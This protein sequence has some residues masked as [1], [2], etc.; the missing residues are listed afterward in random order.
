MKE[1][2]TLKIFSLNAGGTYIK[3]FIAIVLL[4][5]LFREGEEDFSDGRSQYRYIGS[6]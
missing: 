6:F 5:E 3:R 1:N 2:K 4:S